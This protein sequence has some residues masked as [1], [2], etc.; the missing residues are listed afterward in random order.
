MLVEPVC[1]LL[2]L[3]LLLFELEVLFVVPDCYV[4]A[5]KTRDRKGLVLGLVLAR[6][7]L[8]NRV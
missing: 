3:L 1:C 5:M 4:R 6:A 8:R 2:L 7:G